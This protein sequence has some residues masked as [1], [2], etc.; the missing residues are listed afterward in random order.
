[1][2]EDSQMLETDK[3][4][5][6]KY[7]QVR[8][9]NTELVVV[10][11][12]HAFKHALRFGA[13]FVHIALNEG[14][15][16]VS[17]LAKFGTS[18]EVLY[19]QENSI[20]I[21]GTVWESLAPNPPDTGL[22]ALVKKPKT[23][24]DFVG[25]TVVFIESPHSL[26]NIGAIIRTAVAAGVQSF[27]ISGRHNPWHADCVSTARGLNFA[28]DYI[29]II[30]NKE[31]VK[32]AKAGGYTLYALDTHTDITVAKISKSGKKVLMFGTERDGLSKELCNEAEQIV[33]LPM[34]E[35]VSSLNLASSVAASL[36]VLNSP[37]DAK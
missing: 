10:E 35:G 17:V 4:I 22:I 12:V 7:Q 33:R 36:Y 26:F 28:L 34:R 21:T 24:M 9:G 1:M 20:V 14:S 32:L 23:S 5:A 8:K 11:G 3:D 29:S 6:N 13:E 2:R 19:L 15:E 31:L 16:A 18:E 37:S 27:A 25:D 30:D